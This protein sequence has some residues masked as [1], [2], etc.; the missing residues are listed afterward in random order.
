MGFE[1]D[2]GAGLEENSLA[3][4]E[5]IVSL[6]GKGLEEREGTEITGLAQIELKGRIDTYVR[7]MHFV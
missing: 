6:P 7:L 4:I 1:G 2:A 3:A 5:I